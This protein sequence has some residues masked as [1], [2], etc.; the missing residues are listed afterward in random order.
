MQ[1]AAYVKGERRDKKPYEPAEIMV[2]CSPF[3]DPIVSHEI[4]KHYEMF[5]GKRAEFKKRFGI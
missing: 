4:D 2:I 1:R 3:T 5:L